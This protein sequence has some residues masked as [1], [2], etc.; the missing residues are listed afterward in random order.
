MSSDRQQK[1]AAQ[2]VRGPLRVVTDS[3][4]HRPGLFDELKKPSLNLVLDQTMIA[5]RVILAEGSFPLADGPWRNQQIDRGLADRSSL[6]RGP[7]QNHTVWVQPLGPSGR[8]RC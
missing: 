6:F 4:G 5:E 3:A 8:R 1:Y 7:E 2:V